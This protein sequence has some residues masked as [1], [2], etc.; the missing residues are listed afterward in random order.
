MCYHSLSAK[1]QLVSVE[2][3]NEHQKSLTISVSIKAGPYI[4]R[5]VWNSVLC[6]GTVLKK[7]LWE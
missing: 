4:L 3:K 5:D 1:K 6:E 7:V 2:E